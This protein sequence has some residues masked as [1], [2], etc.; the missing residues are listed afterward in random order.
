[1]AEKKDLK[2]RTLK[3][4]EGWVAVKGG[5]ALDL[6]GTGCLFLATPGGVPVYLH[7]FNVVDGALCQ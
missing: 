5:Y 3:V 2:V 4:P 6:P 7:D 1:M